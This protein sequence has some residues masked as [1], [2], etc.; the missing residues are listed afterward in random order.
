VRTTG[1]YPL[2]CAHADHLSAGTP[3]ARIIHKASPAPRYEVH[4]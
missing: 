1:R 4:E 2:S 3:L